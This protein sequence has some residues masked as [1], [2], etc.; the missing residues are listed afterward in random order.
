MRDFHYLP[1]FPC[2]DPGFEEA[3]LSPSV[4]G[5]VDHLPVLS[6]HISET[7]TRADGALH[8]GIATI[9]Q[10]TDAILKYIPVRNVSG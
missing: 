10:G 9:L 2:P 4:T 6:T 5:I 1:N 3:W 7:L 8:T